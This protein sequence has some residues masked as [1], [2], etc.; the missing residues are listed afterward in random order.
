MEHATRAAGVFYEQ[1]QC[2]ICLAG[3]LN[4]FCINKN[5]IQFIAHSVSVQQ[6]ERV[7]LGIIK[8]ISEL[9]EQFWKT[10]ASCERRKRKIKFKTGGTVF[11]KMTYFW[12]I[13]VCTDLL[14]M[15]DILYIRWQNRTLSDPCEGG[16]VVVMNE[17]VY[18]ILS[19]FIFH[20][21]LP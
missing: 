10:S 1:S 15:R 18:M 20:N 13:E 19:F 11:E 4:N 2:I 3:K 9:Q 14:I 17:Q 7:V 8:M 5:S 21:I 6:V 16:I 12:K